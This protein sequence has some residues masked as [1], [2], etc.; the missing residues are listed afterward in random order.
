MVVVRQLSLLTAQVQMNAFQFSLFVME[1]LVTAQIITMKMFNYVMHVSCL[2]Y[3]E[4]IRCFHKVAF[5]NLDERPP[6][7]TIIKFLA[8]EYNNHGFPFMVYLFGNKA[9]S[10]F[11]SMPPEEAYGEIAKNLAT[12]K[13]IDDFAKNVEMTK[14]ERERLQTT[15]EKISFGETN[16]LPTFIKN[17]IGEGLSSLTENLKKTHFF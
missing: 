12:S 11:K 13:T 8:L 5:G 3:V 16:N 2:F 9:A 14:V 7:D 6:K 10:L 1:S 17:S 15:L 4:L